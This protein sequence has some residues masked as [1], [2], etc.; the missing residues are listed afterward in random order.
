MIEV[1]RPLPQ[2]GS[3]IRA[4]TLLAQEDGYTLHSL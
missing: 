1:G 4:G 2:G 3:S